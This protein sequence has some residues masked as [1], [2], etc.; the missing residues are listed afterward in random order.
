[1][2]SEVNDFGVY[3]SSRAYEERCRL[4]TL[5][6]AVVTA[7]RDLLSLSPLV[8]RDYDSEVHPRKLLPGF[9][10]FKIDIQHATSKA[11]KN[12]EDLIRQWENAIFNNTDDEFNFS[13]LS[14]GVVRDCARIYQTRK[15]HPA[16]YLKK[17]RKGR[18]DRRSAKP[19]EVAA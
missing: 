7:Y 18:P 16:I 1:L 11:L 10:D 4:K 15:L 8:A 13:R 17:F 5:F 2:K 9:V 19:I 6:E 12:D 14:Y 3:K